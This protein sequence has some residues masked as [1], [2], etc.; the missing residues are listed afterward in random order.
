MSD[1][2][3][4]TRLAAKSTGSVNIHNKCVDYSSV[5]KAIG[6]FRNPTNAVVK[7]FNLLFI[8]SLLHKIVQLTPRKLIT[9]D[10]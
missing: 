8:T 6:R 2:S 7:V 4:R 3:I 1:E 5:Q 9:Q 10:F